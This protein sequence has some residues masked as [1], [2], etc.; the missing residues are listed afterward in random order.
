[1]EVDETDEVCIDTFSKWV[2]FLCVCVCVCVC[3][4]RKKHFLVDIVGWY[5]QVVKAMDY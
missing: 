1:M 3:V 2:I 5:G 4:C